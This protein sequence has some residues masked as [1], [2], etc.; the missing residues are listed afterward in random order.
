MDYNVI[1]VMEVA[2]DAAEFKALVTELNGLPDVS[3]KHIVI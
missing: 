2:G 3:A 1:A